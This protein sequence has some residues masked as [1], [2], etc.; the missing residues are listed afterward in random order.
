M[1]ELG[2]KYM[3]SPDDPQVVT[4]NGEPQHDNLQR[5]EGRTG[6]HLQK[7]QEY[8]DI[9]KPRLDPIL[10]GGVV[11]INA[12]EHPHK[13]IIHFLFLYLCHPMYALQILPLVNLLQLHH[14][15]FLICDFQRTNNLLSL[16]SFYNLK[17]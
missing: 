13:Q 1:I 14:K 17:I 3:L 8:V 6:W 11:S 2:E 16:A 9:I 10:S 5:L 12:S 15:V 4:P 7:T